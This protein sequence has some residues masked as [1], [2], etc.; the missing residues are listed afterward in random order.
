MLSWD[1]HVKLSKRDLTEA[2][3]IALM[4]LIDEIARVAHTLA[5]LESLSESP[6]RNRLIAKALAL[7]EK[8]RALKSE[9]ETHLDKAIPKQTGFVVNFR[10][11]D[12]TL[13]IGLGN[14]I[15]KRPPRDCLEF[16]RTLNK[17][18]SSIPS[19][20][21]GHALAE[22]RRRCLGH[23]GRRL[24]FIARLSRQVA[25]RAR[26]SL[27]RHA[28][29]RSVRSVCSRSGASR[30]RIVAPTAAPPAEC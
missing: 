30:S 7:R 10:V 14:A 4:P 1:D 15:A 12:L 25:A 21:R 6:E 8:W 17:V 20:S 29:V 18:V 16:E 27:S 28:S 13:A 22:E 19:S 26:E 2:R 24:F 9:R 3:R 5:M 11:F 23:T